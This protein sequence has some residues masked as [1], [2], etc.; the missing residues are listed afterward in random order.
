M[1]GERLELPNAAPGSVQS[2]V[3]TGEPLELEEPEP[4]PARPSITTIPLPLDVQREITRGRIAAALL[5]ILGFLVAGSFVSLWFGWASSTELDALLTLL[6]APVIGLVGAATGFY[7]GEKAGEES[8]KAATK[9]SDPGKG[10][11]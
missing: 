9:T 6:F 1:A 5:A 2:S 11:V 8:E 7:F 4:G 10:G 3:T